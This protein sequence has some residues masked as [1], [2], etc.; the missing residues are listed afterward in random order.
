[1]DEPEIY[2]PLNVQSLSFRWRGSSYEV[3]IGE[4]FLTRTVREWQFCTT[5]KT[6]LSDLL[7]EF[8]VD[9][10][11]SPTAQF[12]APRFVYLLVAALVVQFSVVPRFVPA[13]AP[14]LFGFAL[15]H[16]IH[17]LRHAT[18]VQQTRVLNYYG[19]VVAAIPHL[20]ELEVGRRRFEDQL[21]DAIKKAK[22]LSL[23]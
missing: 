3:S 18:P 8:V 5:T 13:L 22:A 6:S 16:L 14:V 4:R 9:T 17:L 21:R 20:P 11:S 1:M 7:E 12:H 2:L 23:E 19:G 15:I 10:P